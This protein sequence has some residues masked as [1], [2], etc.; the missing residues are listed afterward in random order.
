MWPLLCHRASPNAWLQLGL[1]G[2]QSS[3]S[4]PTPS[5]QLPRTGEIGL[6]DISVFRLPRDHIIPPIPPP[7]PTHIYTQ[8][9]HTYTGRAHTHRRCKT[10]ELPE[11]KQTGINSP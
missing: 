7:P 5:S 1:A 10:L 8:G 11:A 2:W 6:E 9:A 3:H 4:Q